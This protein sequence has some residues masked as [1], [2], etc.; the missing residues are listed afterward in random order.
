MRYQRNLKGYTNIFDHGRLT[1][2]GPDIVRCRPTS[3]RQPEIAMAACKPEVV[4]TREQYVISARY[5][6]ILDIFG[7]VQHGGAISNI[8]RC[9]PTSGRQPEIAMAA[10]KTEVV[11]TEER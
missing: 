4:I 8:A 5:Q 2:T 1:G 6:R 9:C 7:Q 11:I 3:G 10:Y